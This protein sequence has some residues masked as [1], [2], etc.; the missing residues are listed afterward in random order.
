M[1]EEHKDLIDAVRQTGYEV[2]VYFKNGFLEKV[3]ENALA[4]RLRKQ[5]YKVEQQ[6]QLMVYD[7]DGS[8][9]GE[10]FADLLVEGVLVV[11]LKAA[12]ALADAHVAQVLSYLKTSRL[13]HAVL[14]NFG[15]PKFQVKAFI[16]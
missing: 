14:M 7:E 1:N 13:R 10:Y 6:R 9:V 4:N 11:E 3:Y 5:G 8:I 2:H 16:T 15:A 12:S